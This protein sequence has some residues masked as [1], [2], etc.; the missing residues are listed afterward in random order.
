MNKKVATIILNRNLGKLTDKLYRKI[1][2]NNS[3]YTDI[4][5][6][7]AG[8]LEKHKSKYTNWTSNSKSV[9]KMVLDLEEE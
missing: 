7:D 6:M 8:S 2:K 4:F 9:K 1:K 3:K 5:V